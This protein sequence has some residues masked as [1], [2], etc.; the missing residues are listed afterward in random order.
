[1][2]CYLCQGFYADDGPCDEGRPLGSPHRAAI[3]EARHQRALQARRDERERSRLAE[4]TFTRHNAP[5]HPR[6]FRPLSPRQGG[7][8]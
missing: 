3:D 5:A 2:N 1:M 4:T 8:S 6:G 7:A